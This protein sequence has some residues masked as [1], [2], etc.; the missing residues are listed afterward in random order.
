MDDPQWR[1]WEVTGVI[2]ERGS[3]QSRVVAPA[4]KRDSTEMNC[5]EEI[6]TIWQLDGQGPGR[7]M[8]NEK[9]TNNLRISAGVGWALEGSGLGQNLAWRERAT[10]IW[11]GQTALR[12]LQGNKWRKQ[13]EPDG[14]AILREV[15]GRV[16]RGDRL[17]RERGY[18]QEKRVK[19]WGPSVLSC[20]ATNYTAKMQGFSSAQTPAWLGFLARGHFWSTEILLKPS[21]PVHFK[22]EVASGT[23]FLD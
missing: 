4:M 10:A 22:S 19:S 11:F 23:W 18:W 17:L 12:L 3:D 6:N 5:E 20:S 1:Q 9:V 2:Q 16:L 8:W 13:R 21:R 7:T 14:K 15:T